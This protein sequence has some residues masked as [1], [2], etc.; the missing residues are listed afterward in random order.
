MLS[1]HRQRPHADHLIVVDDV[2]L[3][4]EQPDSDDVRGVKGVSFSVCPGEFVFI[5][6]QSGHGKT[7]LLH[8]LHGQT[9]PQRGRITLGGVDLRDIDRAQLRR[10]VALASSSLPAV[11]HL[12]VEENLRFPLELLHENPALIDARVDELLGVFGLE[13]A[14][15]RPS[16]RTL[17]DGER[18]RL[19]IARAI[20]PKPDLLLCDEPTGKVDPATTYGVARTLN[21][22]AMMGTTVICVTHDPHM[23]DLMHRRVIRLRD[24]RVE[25]DGIGGYQ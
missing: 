23:V 15:R 8:L 2:H 19:E 9:P 6:G 13:H 24:G 17:S 25:F 1:R 16:D 11:E 20:A 14:R 21:R 4:Y 18:Q 10:K 5:T 12:T 22:V 3:T 7:T